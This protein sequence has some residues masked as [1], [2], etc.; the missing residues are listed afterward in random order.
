MTIDAIVDERALR[1]IYLA[2]FER[3]YKYFKLCYLMCAYNKVNGTYCSEHPR[4]M[5]DILKNEWGHQ[6]LVVTDWGAMNERVAGLSAGIELEM[7]GAPNGND[8]IPAS[9]QN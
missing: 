4:L 6:G 5:T 9:I 3:V 1:E 7:P 8:A 2:G